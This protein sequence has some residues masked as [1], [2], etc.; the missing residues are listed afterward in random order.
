MHLVMR[1]SRTLQHAMWSAMPT[2]LPCNLRCSRLLNCG[3]QCPSICGENCPGEEFCQQCCSSEIQHT[4][5]DYL[6]FAT[7]GEINLDADPIIILPCKHFC[8]RTSLDRILEID[9][10]YITDDN[11]QFVGSIPNGSMTSQR[12]QCPQCRSPISQIQRYNRVIK[13]CVLDTLLKSIISRSQ[14]RYLELAASLD[15][16]KLEMDTS[17]EE[18]LGKLRPI[19]NPMQKRPLNKKNAAV[20]IDRLKSFDLLKGKIRGYL[21]EVDETR[22]P[23]MKVYQ[24]SIAAQSRAKTTIEG[25]PV[26]CWPLDVPSPDIKHRILGT[27]LDLR[28]EVSRYADMIQLVN[29]LSSLPD[30]K[31]MQF[32]F[33]TISSRNARQSAQKQPKIRLNATSVNIILSRWKFFFFKPNYRH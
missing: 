2:R 9:K 26:A 16:F 25:V 24:M 15:E 14:A 23:H 20:I 7:Y 11:D 21:K 19:R 17:R 33:T 3:H 27:I 28:S 12:A 4:V 32:R 18:S 13:R 8:S 31:R 29:Q 30:V 6:E 1:A 10:V 5:V 22:Q